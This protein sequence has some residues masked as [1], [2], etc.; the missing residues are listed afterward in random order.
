LFVYANGGQKYQVN[1][2]T[3]LVRAA[4]KTGVEKK[5]L[6]DYGYK[7]LLLAGDITKSVRGAVISQLEH[8]WSG[9]LIGE[10]GLKDPPPAPP[11]KKRR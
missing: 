5:N 4:V 1:D 11:G 2:L 9:V 6:S 10:P 3:E 8:L 7:R